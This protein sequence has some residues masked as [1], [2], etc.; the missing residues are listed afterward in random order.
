M[1]AAPQS[2]EQIRNDFIAAPEIDPKD[3]PKMFRC[4]F[5]VVDEQLKGKKE[6]LEVWN[7]YK[8]FLVFLTSKVE[9]CIKKHGESEAER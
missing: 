2:S 4:G 9:A 5:Q 1:I 3:I 8:P 7:E 6:L